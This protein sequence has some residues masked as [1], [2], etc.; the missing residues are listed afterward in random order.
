MR[1]FPSPSV[2]KIGAPLILSGAF[3]AARQLHRFHHRCSASVMFS[4]L[5]SAS[6]WLHMRLNFASV[7][8]CFPSLFP[9]MTH[10]KRAG[11]EIMS[12]EYGEPPR[13]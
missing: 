12:A 11:A 5:F 6:Q 13:V 8:H 2:G 1:L 10:P 7:F 4:S 3:S 9:R